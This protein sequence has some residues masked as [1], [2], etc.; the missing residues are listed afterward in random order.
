M[1]SMMLYVKLNSMIISKTHDLIHLKISCLLQIIIVLSQLIME[2][3][4]RIIKNV[5]IGLIFICCAFGESFGQI[6]L[7]GGINLSNFIGSDSGDAKEVMGLNAGI[8]LTLIRFGPVS[9]TPEIYYAE[10]GARFTDQLRDLQNF[11][12]ELADQDDP[13]NLEFNLAY[14]ELPVLLKIHLPFISTEGVKPYIGGGPVFGWRIDCNFKLDS[15]LESTAEQCTNENFP[16]L[17]TTFKEADR[18]YALNSGIDF[19]IPY[20]GTITLDARYIRGLER[21][22]ASDENSDIQNQSFSLM[23]G[24]TFLF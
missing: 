22:S 2:K 3:L 23:L 7:R 10:K 13:Y 4:M 19:I 5:T 24:Y 6:G 9:I 20:L 15:T 12:P 18:G 11:D 1:F 21:V 8:S 14:I 17:E 16:D